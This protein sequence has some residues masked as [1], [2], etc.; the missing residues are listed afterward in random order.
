MLV[1][2]FPNGGTGAFNKDGI[3]I[4][5]V[6]KSWIVVYADYLLSIGLDPLDV[7][8]ELP[9]GKNAKIRIKP[10]SDYTWEVL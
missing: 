7:D 8:F 2:F 1:I 5:K 6:A 9:D 10:D 3:Q 4:P